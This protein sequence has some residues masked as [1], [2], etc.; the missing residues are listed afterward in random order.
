M[1]GC[2]AST[3]NEARVVIFPQDLAATY[4]AD[5]GR[6]AAKDGAISDTELSAW[7]SAIADLHAHGRLFGSV[8]YFLFTA[9]R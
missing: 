4:F 1:P 3:T 6:N 8:G 5:T 7:L 9:R 2:P